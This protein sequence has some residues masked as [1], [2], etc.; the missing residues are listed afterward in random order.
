MGEKSPIQGFHALMLAGA[1]QPPSSG[2]AGC[3]PRAAGA[4]AIP[5]VTAACLH[6]QLGR[7]RSVT[8]V[9]VPSYGAWQR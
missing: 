7:S 3:G 1:P 4:G 5:G 8:A 9:G 6:S 2:L